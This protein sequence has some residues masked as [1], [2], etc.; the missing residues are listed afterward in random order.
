MN[1]S[2]DWVKLFELY[3]GLLYN[4]EL[5]RNIDTSKIPTAL[6]KLTWLRRVSIFSTSS[7]LRFE[8]KQ[9]LDNGENI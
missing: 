1:L 5:K 7:N 9:Y 3:F 8:M 6:T 4:V 2:F